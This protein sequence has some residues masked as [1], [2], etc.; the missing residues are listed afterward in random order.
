[1]S[2]VLERVQGQPV[3]LPS[4]L[5]VATVERISAAVGDRVVMGQE[6]ATVKAGKM[7]RTI[8]A[9]VAGHVRSLVVG[10]GA[11]VPA[12]G[13]LAYIEPESPPVARRKA[14]ERARQAQPSGAP[15]GS[16]QAPRPVQRPPEPPV[17]ASKPVEEE[18]PTPAKKGQRERTKH[19]GFYILPSQERA[20]KR[21][22]ID[23]S[24]NEEE[25]IACNDS[26]VVR[27]AIDA[28]LSMA[29]AA[30]RATLERYKSK[31]KKA[32]VGSGWPRPGKK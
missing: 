14:P 25:P 4:G 13:V 24:L 31:E 19:R 20:L 26:L 32:G 9:P 6:I 15:N 30:Q 3:R 18:K 10:E 22:V 17:V 5:S 16:H 2:A 27:A 21:L 28:F 11:T 23:T 8:G 7:W 29:P 1:M 12:G